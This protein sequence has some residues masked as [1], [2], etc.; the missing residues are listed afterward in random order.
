MRSRTG[1]VDG[2]EL[3]W[4]GLSLGAK[5]TVILEDGQKANKLGP[6]VG[7]RVELRWEKPVKVHRCP[8]L[9]QE[10]CEIRFDDAAFRWDLFRGSLMRREELVHQGLSFCPACGDRLEP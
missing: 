1:L 5:V 6:E 2:V 8:G 7:D 4:R 3:W 10:R 9:E